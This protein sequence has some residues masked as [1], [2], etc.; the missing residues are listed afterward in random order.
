MTPPNRAEYEV[1]LRMQD[2]THL[3][4]KTL[5]LPAKTV[6]KTVFTTYSAKYVRIAGLGGK[7]SPAWN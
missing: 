7:T 3:W 4:T 1:A 5:R 2:L 6:T